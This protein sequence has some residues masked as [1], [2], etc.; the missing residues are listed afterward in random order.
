MYYYYSHTDKKPKYC[1]GSHT[2]TFLTNQKK[3][4]YT[5]YIYAE[6]DCGKKPGEKKAKHKKHHKR[7]HAAKRAVNGTIA[8]PGE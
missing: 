6:L 2:H 4:V 1:F 8:D 7:G 5:F 3:F